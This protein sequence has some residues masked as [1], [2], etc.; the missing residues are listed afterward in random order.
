YS[1][2][3]RLNGFGEVAQKKLQSAS[4]LVIG[5]GGLGCPAL[6]YLT[7]AGVGKIGI[8]D[9][10]RIELS[11]LQR[12]VLFSTKE[13]GLYKAEVT[14]AK[15]RLLN[16]EIEILEYVLYLSTENAIE[17]IEAYDMVLDCTDNFATRYLLSDVCALLDKPLVFGAIYRYEGQLAVFNVANDEGAKTTYRHLFPS[18]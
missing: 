18:P 10:D 2:H 9:N 6:Q 12:Q 1:R 17:R 4:V 16:P 3:Y 15:L 13:I 7:A 5:A 8:V 11:N 14:A